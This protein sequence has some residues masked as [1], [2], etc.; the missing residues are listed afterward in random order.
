MGHIRT[1]DKS[2]LFLFSSCPYLSGDSIFLFSFFLNSKFSIDCVV[3]SSQKH[4]DCELDLFDCLTYNQSML[5]RPHSHTRTR[6]LTVSQSVSVNDIYFCLLFFSISD[7][8][9]FIIIQY[10]WIHQ[11]WAIAQF[12]SSRSRRFSRRLVSQSARFL[13]WVFLILFFILIRSPKAN[14]DLAFDNSNGA[15]KTRAHTFNTELDYWLLYSLNWWWCLHTISIPFCSLLLFRLALCHQSFCSHW[16]L[17]AQ[18]TNI[19]IGIRI[20]RGTESEKR[21]TN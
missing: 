5:N 6:S 17:F 13:L 2:L 1:H 12:F 15:T 14:A 4:F 8:N 21:R 20:D 7:F 3:L 19:I 16:I 9:K 11:M 10:I 18:F